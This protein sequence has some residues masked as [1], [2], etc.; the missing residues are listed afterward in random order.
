MTFESQISFLYY[1]N[2]AKACEFYEKIF[3]F[4]LVIDQGWAKIYK[5]T[6]GALLGLVDETKGHFNWQKEKTIMITLV[7]SS[8]DEVDEWYAKLKKLDVKLVFEPRDVEEI[9]IRCFLFEDPEGY[10]VEIQHFL[11]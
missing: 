7:T 6:N 4:D 11:K 5:V 8:I 1:K 2:L 9:N 10:V 3:G